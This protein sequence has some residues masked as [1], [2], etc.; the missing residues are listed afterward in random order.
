MIKPFENYNYQTSFITENGKQ[1]FVEK[2]V[3]NNKTTKINGEEITH[4][5]KT[6]QRKLSNKEIED[7]FNKNIFI[8]NINFQLLR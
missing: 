7:L 1:I 5:G 6:R 2:E 3:I 8:E 4:N